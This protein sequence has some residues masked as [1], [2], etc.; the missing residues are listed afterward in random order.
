MSLLLELAI[1]LAVAKLAADLALRAG[2]PAVLGQLVAGLALGVVYAVALPGLALPYGDELHAFADIGLVLIMFLAG[3]ETDWPQLRAA[4]RASFLAASAGVA[5]PL[6]A[7]WATARAFG[8]SDVE[9]VFVGVILT[10]TSVSITAQTL[11]ELG[12]IGTLEGVTIL[13]AAVIDDVIG[14]IVFSIAI[15]MS[16]GKVA[17]VIPPMPVLLGSAAAFTV[18][19]LA[20]PRLVRFGHAMRA[21]E[22]V[23]GIALALAFLLGAFAQGSGVAAI[24]GSYIAGVLIAR[25]H[26]RSELIEKVRVIGHALFIPVFLV[27]TGMNARLDTIGPAMLFVV[28]LTVVAVTTKVVGSGAGARLAGLS[29]R[30]SL[31]V[32][33]GMVARGEVAI[34]V[35]GLAL[36]AGAISAEVFSAAVVVVLA[37]T[38]VTPLLLRLVLP[39][40]RAA[41]RRESLEAA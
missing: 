17:S 10:A 25:S 40:A 9:A 39:A 29:S 6:V 15:A 1:V 26:V 4:G 21:D 7:G 8:M 5:V 30:S 27:M 18:V 11:V 34:V 41:G 38:L 3:L 19:A 13:G 16:G 14:I 22:S 35:A 31:V 36:S 20:I 2:Q 33:V 23:L 28:V 37:T 24:T 12:S 32:G